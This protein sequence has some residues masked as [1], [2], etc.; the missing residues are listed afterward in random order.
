M[1]GDQVEINKEKYRDFEMRPFNIVTKFILSKIKEQ[2]VS[3][4]G[5]G[6]TNGVSNG[7]FQ[8]NGV[9]Q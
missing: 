7:V 5:G 6:V 9:S 2:A 8:S 3:N 1:E 4:G